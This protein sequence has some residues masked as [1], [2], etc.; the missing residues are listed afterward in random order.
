MKLHI[1]LLSRNAIMYYKPQ[2][3]WSSSCIADKRC[4][5]K[6]LTLQIYH[7]ERSIQM[8]KCLWKLSFR[9]RQWITS[10]VSPQTVSLCEWFNSEINCKSK[11]YFDSPIAWILRC[12]SFGGKHV[13]LLGQPTITNF[14]HENTGQDVALSQS[15]NMSSQHVAQV[16]HFRNSSY[17]LT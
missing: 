13:I 6:S 2:S 5:D 8:T 1:T 12:T 14:T 16:S 10:S 4:L 9:Q 7:E 3:D 15:L 11:Q 17:K